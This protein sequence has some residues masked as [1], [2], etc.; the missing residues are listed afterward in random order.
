MMWASR[1]P[2]LIAALV[3]QF[4]VCP[5][6]AD[7]AIRDGPEIADEAADEVLSVGWSGIEGETG[8]ESTIT[9]DGLGNPDREMCTIRCTI[10]VLQ[11]STDIVAARARAYALLTAA[12]SAIASDRTLDRLA[13]RAQIASVSLDQT[14]T[15]QGAQAVLMFAVDCDT[16]TAR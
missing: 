14:Q 15:N 11:G 2:D 8:V 9:V 5:D 3:Q 12:G 16:F 10:G 7:V 6:L 1:A 4:T 13:L